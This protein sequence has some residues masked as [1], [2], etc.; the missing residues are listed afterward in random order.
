MHGVSII[1][2]ILLEPNVLTGDNLNFNSD[3]RN[4]TPRIQ[5]LGPHR[6]DCTQWRQSARFIVR[7]LDF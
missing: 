6:T 1:L 7:A 2:I 5:F 4:F 3:C